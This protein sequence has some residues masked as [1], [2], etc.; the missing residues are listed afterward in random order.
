MESNL[1]NE[2]E[3]SFFLKSSVRLEPIMWR[4]YAWPQLI[5]PLT[6][7]LNIVNRH[8]KLM[9]SFVEAP[10]VHLA[11]AN[12][13]SLIGGAF[14]NLK[15]S[16]VPFVRE[17]ITQT[18]KQ[19]KPFIELAEAITYFDN[20]LKS[21][22][23]GGSLEN[24][25]S[26]VPDLLKGM[27]E[28]V[29]DAH[30]N[31]SMRFIEPLVY[32][33]H[34]QDSEQGFILVDT[35]QD[36]RPFVLSTPRLPGDEELFIK[37]PFSHNATDELAKLRFKALPFAEIREMVGI[38]E[39]EEVKL[40]NFL[41]PTP[42]SVGEESTF[43][44]NGVKVRYFG[45]ACILLET[46]NIRILIDPVISYKYPT[47]IER[48][49]LNDLPDEID[50]VLFTH[51]HDDHVLL[52][53]LLQIRHK[54]KSFVVPSSTK[55]FLLDPS[56]KNILNVT[57]FKNVITLDEFES[58]DLAGGKIVGIP[59]LGEHCDLNIQSKLGYYIKLG[60]TSFLFA[61]DSNNLD[62]PLYQN[63]FS[64]V[65][66][67]DICFIGMECVGAPMSWLYG[68]L[69]PTPLSHH[70]DQQR[71]LDGSNF[72]KAW[73]ILHYAQPR[74][75]YIYALGQEPWLNYVMATHYTEASPVMINAQKLIQAC[76]DHNI[77]AK[78]LFAKDEWIYR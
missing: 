64:M 11:A 5:S 16:H 71:R 27:V 55:G 34:Y 59:F 21:I 51:A 12:N 2:K 74:E 36:Y 41:T 45:H 75:V 31:A 50:Y 61:A 48:Y 68:P 8:L 24:F 76:K 44:G 70:H 78:K 37:L 42:P 23:D 22:A 52:E 54:V 65:G 10:E 7:S 62:P 39:T 56:L 20:L 26:L 35:N 15:E 67:A 69:L 14:I 19:C 1:H 60:K 72:E 9:E 63:I 57:G 18:K 38:P 49:T 43:H 73:D 40:K 17:M 25:Y 29:Y 66:K 30:N 58:L 28:L 32:R 77:T 13:A 3:R 47:E 6:A 4:W 53:T 46:S 33:N